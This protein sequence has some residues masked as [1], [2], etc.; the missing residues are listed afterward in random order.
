MRRFRWYTRFPEI[1][2][3]EPLKP[4]DKVGRDV[5]RRAFQPVKLVRVIRK[6]KELVGRKN[7]YKN[8]TVSTFEMKII[9]VSMWSFLT[10]RWKNKSSGCTGS[11]CY[12]GIARLLLWRL[13]IA[14]TKF[15]KSAK[16]MCHGAKHSILRFETVWHFFWIWVFWK[17]L[18]VFGN[19][20]R[21]WEHHWWRGDWDGLNRLN[22]SWF[23]DL[24]FT[25]CSIEENMLKTREQTDYFLFWLFRI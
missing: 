13:E 8:L 20:Q 7:K 9:D 12:L 4:A 1:I 22:F 14:L 17:F 18:K 6:Q 10:F 23:C 5:T 2:A 25:L 11:G 3:P 15:W 16:K 21:I 24:L 19:N